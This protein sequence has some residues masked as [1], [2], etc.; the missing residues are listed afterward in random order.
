[1]TRED[2]AEINEEALIIDG[3]DSA[4]IGMAERINLGPVVAYDE[5]KIIDILISQMELDD[6]EGMTEDEIEGEKVTMAIEHFEYNIKGAWLGEYTPVFIR[7]SFID[8]EYYSAT[9]RERINLTE[10]FEDQTGYG[11]WDY[12]G[13]I[14]TKIDSFPDN[15]CDGQ[16]TR[17][18]VQRESDGKFFEFT[19][20]L[21][22]S[23]NYHMDD[24]MVQVF[25]KTI[26]TKIYE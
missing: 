11:P 22:F 6:T 24:E 12:E 8:T 14:Y 15:N 10:D 18:I 26:T 7:G 16:C 1:M 4:I 20:M 21:S 19:W 9:E 13:E 17:V 25:P 23:E 3:F 5:E 2:I